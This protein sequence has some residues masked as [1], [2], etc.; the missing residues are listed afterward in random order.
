L[1]NNKF[2]TFLKLEFFLCIITIGGFTMDEKTNMIV[3]L[4]LVIAIVFLAMNI[5]GTD[6]R[7]DTISVSGTG[8]V[9]VEPDEAVVQISILTEGD[10]AEFVQRQ[11][12]DIMED[13]L[14]ELKAYGISEDDI[15]TEYY[16]LY[17]MTSWDYYTDES[18]IYGYR[19]T[20]TLSITTTEIKDTGKIVDIAVGAGANDVD[21]V[22]FQLSE[23]AME[24]AYAEALEKASASAKSKAKSIAD[25]MGVRLGKVETVTESSAYASPY[26][27]LGIESVM[28]D[29]APTT[30]SPSDGEVN[31]YVSVVYKI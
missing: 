6:E 12:A 27:A 15:E 25:G 16:Y 20:H 28:A 1:S 13:V 29:L 10:D 21:R 14:E 23:E 30:I 31:A 11:N 8:K 2:I 4:G 22:N 7:K 9:T 18:E 5:G 3:A 17:P 26:R 19:L 24:K